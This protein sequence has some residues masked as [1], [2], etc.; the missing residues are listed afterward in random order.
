[1]PEPGPQPSPGSPPDHPAPQLSDI[2]SLA[3]LSKATDKT[4]ADLLEYTAKELED[5][6]ALYKVDVVHTRSHIQTYNSRHGVM[7]VV[8]KS[9]V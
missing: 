6:F 2:R 8:L 9:A 7:L 5:V 3:A 1:M 4:E